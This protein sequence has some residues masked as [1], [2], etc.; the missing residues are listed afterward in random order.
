[1]AANYTNSNSSD[2]RGYVPPISP[3]QA[4]SLLQRAGIPFNMPTTTA[5]TNMPAVRPVAARDAAGATMNTTTTTTPVAAVT[6]ATN[7]A[8]V[9][10]PTVPPKDIVVIDLTSDSDTEVSPQGSNSESPAPLTQET[11]PLTEFHRRFREKKL[12]WLH[13]SNS[14]DADAAVAEAI[15]QGLNSR[16]RKQ[17]LGDGFVGATY[18]ECYRHG[19]AQK[20]L[21]SGST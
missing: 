15:C 14:S 10:T 2:R 12:S 13:E 19:Q 3:E 7:G 21:P 11:S 6:P 17:E 18:S 1:M 20:V 4:A 8:T 5:A 9:P 16:K